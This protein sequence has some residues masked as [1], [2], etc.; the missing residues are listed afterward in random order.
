MATPAA[1]AA[2]NFPNP[3]RSRLLELAFSWLQSLKQMSTDLDFV[4]A[5]LGLHLGTAI[6]GAVLTREQLLRQLR[7]LRQFGRD[8]AMRQEEFNNLTR[9]QQV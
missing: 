6:E 7:T 8:F 9:R 4:N 3:Y 5:L 1:A 2:D